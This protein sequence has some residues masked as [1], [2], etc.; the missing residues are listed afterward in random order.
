M[1]V[2]GSRGAGH[3]RGRRSPEP[4]SRPPRG[5]QPAGVRGR[6]PELGLEARAQRLRQLGHRGP[7]GG[8][9]VGRDDERRQVGIG[10][11]AVVVRVFLAA[12]A[13]GLVPIRVVE[14]GLLDHRAAVLDEFDLAAHLEVDGALQEAEGVQVLDLAAGAEG[15][16]AERSDRDIGVTAERPLLHVAVADAQ[17]DHQGMQRPGIGHRLAR[18]AH[19]GLAHDLEQRCAGAV[20]V[21]ARHAVKVLVQRLAGVLL[22]MGAGEAHRARTGLAALL[23]GDVEAATGHHRD[24]VLADLVALGQVGIEVVLAGEHR[25]RRHLCAHGQTQPDRA[26]HRRAVHHRQHPGQ[27]EIHRARLG[28]GRRAEGGGRAREDLGARGELRMRLQPDHHLPLH[29]CVSF[30]LNRRRHQRSVRA[31][32]PER[33]SNITGQA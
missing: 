12:H 26:F 16:L 9:P 13:A 3:R 2:S 6:Q 28:V 18:G 23:P 7:H 24:L 14:P 27:G 5:G 25:A 33:G 4:G 21:D 8:D 32:A 20:Q 17:P 22:E 10:E 30:W 15:L 31:Q 11:V 19:V 29:R 1:G